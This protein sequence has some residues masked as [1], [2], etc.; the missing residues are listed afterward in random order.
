ML[1]CYLVSLEAR[2]A[3]PSAGVKEWLEA[4]K[5]R[6]MLHPVQK[7]CIEKALEFLPKL[8]ECLAARAATADDVPEPIFDDDGF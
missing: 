7:K 1:A 2:D 8:Q 6:Y 3:G 4:Q 5:P